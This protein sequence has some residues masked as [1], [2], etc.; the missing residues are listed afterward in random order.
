MVYR[1]YL[2]VFVTD[3]SSENGHLRVQTVLRLI[4]YKGY[5]LVI[6]HVVGNLVAAV[7]RL[8]VK[9]IGDSG[10]LEKIAVDLIGHV[11]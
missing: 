9:Y 8:T 1:F 5:L 11:A 4:V 2:F 10:L 6:H 7:R 3:E